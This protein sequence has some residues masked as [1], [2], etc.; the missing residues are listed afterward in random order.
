M[1]TTGTLAARQ[2]T[3]IFCE[4]TSSTIPRL[5]TGEQTHSVRNRTRF[6]TQPGDLALVRPTRKHSAVVVPC[7]WPIDLLSHITIDQFAMNLAVFT[8]FTYA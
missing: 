3:F 8:I 4:P 7:R 5:K 1:M 2:L 6:P